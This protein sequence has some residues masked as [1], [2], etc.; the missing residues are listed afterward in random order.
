MN[1]TNPT[2]WQIAFPTLESYRDNWLKASQEF[3]AKSFVG[4]STLEA[5]YARCSIYEINI[6]ANRAL[7][8]KKFTGRVE[9]LD[10]TSISGDRQT[11]YR[12]HKINGD[13][14]IVGFI[15][16]LPL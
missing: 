3:R 1:S 15:G 8:I 13:W 11:V 9:C 5:L 10:G 16:F 2:D 7:A 12:L 6:N 14:K 4:L